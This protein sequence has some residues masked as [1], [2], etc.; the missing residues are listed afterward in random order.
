MEAKNCDRCRQIF[1][2]TPKVHVPKVNHD[3]TTERVLT[4]TFEE[5]ISV[6]NLKEMKEKKVPFKQVSERISEAFVKMIFVEGFIHA[7]PHPGNMKVRFNEENDE[8]ELVLLDHGIYA[9]I[10]DS[11]RLSYT[12]LWRGILC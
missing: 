5:G 3:F 2:D 7:D 12:K 8:L 10:S 9:E 1:K 11:T 4:M 6:A